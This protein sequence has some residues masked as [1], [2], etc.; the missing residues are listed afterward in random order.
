MWQWGGALDRY[1]GVAFARCC[2]LIL[3]LEAL[4]ATWV[5]EQPAG[6]NDVIVGHHRLNWLMNEVLY[7]SW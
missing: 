2:L 4:H 5:L 7:A 1:E 3:L 6:A